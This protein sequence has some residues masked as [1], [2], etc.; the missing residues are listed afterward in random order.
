MSVD[1]G[2]GT[3][4]PLNPRHQA[5]EPPW[6]EPPVTP[7][8][9]DLLASPADLIDIRHWNLALGDRIDTTQRTLTGLASVLL[10]LVIVFGFL[11][12]RESH[13]IGDLDTARVAD[14]TQQLT[15][16]AQLRAALCATDTALI[17]G[18][19]VTSRRLWPAG[20]DNYDKTT[21][22]LRQASERLR[23]AD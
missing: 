12:Y 3:P 22:T 2:T 14:T 17:N 20:P 10:V 18:Y 9:T 4:P 16:N 11:L 8:N 15:V 6:P 7:S 5:P 21:L 13:R 23:C 19:N 1:D